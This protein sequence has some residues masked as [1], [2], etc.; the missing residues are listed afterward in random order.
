MLLMWDGRREAGQWSSLAPLLK[1]IFNRGLWLVLGLVLAAR[2][3]DGTPQVL[4]IGFVL[5]VFAFVVVR[6]ITD[7]RGSPETER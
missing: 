1:V 7:G 4:L 5:V 6:D 3:F 2:G